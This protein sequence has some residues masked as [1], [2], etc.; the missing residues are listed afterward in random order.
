MRELFKAIVILVSIIITII[1]SVYA[2][3]PDPTGVENIT[4]VSSSSQNASAYSPPLVAAE[5]NNITSLNIVGTSQTQTWQGYY[6]NISGTII[7]EDASNWTLYSWVALHPQG[8]IYAANKSSVTWSQIKCVNYTGVPNGGNDGVNLSVLE[9]MFGLA[10]ND[11]DGVNETFSFNGTV[12][13]GSV[14]HTGFYVGQYPIAGGS[15]P[16]TD[17]YENDAAAGTNFQEVL[18]TDNESIIFTTIIEND[19]NS[20]ITGV[21]GFNNRMW[22]FQILVGDNG[23]NGDNAAT[24]YYFFVELE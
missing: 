14:N 9:D 1:G 17:T 5:A 8:E 24:S 7:L 19:Q 13:G 2:V 23:H 6:G 3:A 12:E 10:S 21:T 11:E 15:C 4:E 18:L 16:A 22:D 20:S